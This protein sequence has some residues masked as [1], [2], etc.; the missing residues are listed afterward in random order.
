M[1]NFEI[2]QLTH[3]PTC[4]FAGAKE[5]F[6]VVGSTTLPHPPKRPSGCAPRHVYI[7]PRTH[8]RCKSKIDFKRLLRSRVDESVNHSN[9]VAL[10]RL[11]ID[12]QGHI[13]S[14]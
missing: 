13:L 12:A 10:L 11:A 4:T 7:P 5:N 2:L 3:L 8:S 1:N 6:N 14:P 9:L